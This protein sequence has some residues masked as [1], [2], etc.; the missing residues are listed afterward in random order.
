MDLFYSSFYGT[1]KVTEQ[2]NTEIIYEG[3]R[4]SDGAVNTTPVMRDQNYWRNFYSSYDEN[5][6]EDGSFIKL[7]EITLSYAIPQSLIKRTPFQSVGVSITGRNL[8]IKSNFS[9]KDPEGNLLGD[10]NAQGFY[11][12]VTPGTKGFTFGLN[13]K[14]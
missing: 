12:A 6:I 3:I 9:F 1:A 10:T 13:A 5:F 11:H 2:R 7:R 14:F 4:E 8:W